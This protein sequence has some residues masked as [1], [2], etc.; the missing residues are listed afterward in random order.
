MSR[1][2]TPAVKIPRNRLR[3]SVT[4]VHEGGRHAIYTSLA[5]DFANFERWIIVDLPG[6][7]VILTG[8]ACVRGVI[9]SSNA[10]FI[11]FLSGLF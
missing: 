1:I 6:F 11:F 3:V 10:F 5:A 9:R 4:R 7:G 2:I 8:F